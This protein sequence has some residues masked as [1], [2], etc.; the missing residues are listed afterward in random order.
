MEGVVCGP[1]GRYNTM[2]DERVDIA[3][4]L[5]M[6]RI[7]MRVILDICELAHRDARGAPLCLPEGGQTEEVRYHLA[8]CTLCARLY[9]NASRAYA[10]EVNDR[11]REPY[12]PVARAPQGF[13]A[14]VGAGC[15]L[16]QLRPAEGGQ[17]LDRLTVLLEW[18]R[19][20]GRPTGAPRW[21]LT[22]RVPSAHADSDRGADEA[23]LR[24]FDGFKLRVR[25]ELAGRQLVQAVTRLGFDPQRNLVSVPRSLPGAQPQKAERVTLFPLGEEGQEG[26]D[27]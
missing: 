13:A 15:R 5:D 17:G 16:Q 6:I 26:A 21:W 25:L 7:Y 4:Y 24:R 10:E 8:Q 19:E 14:A 1:G 20:S 22:L 23:V 12:A 9:R 2:P 11:A 3:D 18:N 27:W